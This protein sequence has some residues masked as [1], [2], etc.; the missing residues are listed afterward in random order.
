M[1]DKGDSE[2][3]QGQPLSPQALPCLSPLQTVDP[4]EACT[5]MSVGHREWGDMRR[6]H[7]LGGHHADP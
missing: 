4:K 2:T 3:A 5:E 7:S 6:V 1:P